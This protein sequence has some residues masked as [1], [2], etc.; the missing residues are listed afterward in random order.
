MHKVGNGVFKLE[1]GRKP[2]APKPKREIKF[3]EKRPGIFVID[4]EKGTI[5]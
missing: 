2:A 3:I 4:M 1:L 5:V